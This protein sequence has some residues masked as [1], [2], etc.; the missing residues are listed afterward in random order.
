MLALVREGALAERLKDDLGCSSKQLAVGVL[1]EHG[2]PEPS[3]V[4]SAAIALARSRSVVAAPVHQRRDG[5]GE[6]VLVHGRA[7][8]L[9]VFQVDVAGEQPAEALDHAAVLST[10]AIVE[11]S[12][13]AGSE[14]RAEALIESQVA[15]ELE[16]L[17]VEDDDPSGRARRRRTSTSSGG[18]SPDDRDALL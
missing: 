17:A 4:S 18:V 13:A 3:S 5:L 16:P 11:R 7:V 1:V 12:V 10:A 9:L 8:Q 15:R 2:R 14:R 6:P